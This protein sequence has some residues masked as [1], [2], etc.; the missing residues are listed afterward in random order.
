[1]GKIDLNGVAPKQKVVRS[2]LPT[3]AKGKTSRKDMG[4]NKAR[5]PFD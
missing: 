5:E 4:G 1:M 2:A 3:G